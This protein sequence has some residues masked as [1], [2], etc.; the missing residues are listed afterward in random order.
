LP[1]PTAAEVLDAFLSCGRDACPDAARRIA[2]EIAA[3]GSLEQAA[4]GLAEDDAHA[5]L[6]DLLAYRA[7]LAER[8]DPALRL[9]RLY[10]EAA[11]LDARAEPCWAEAAEF[12]GRAAFR[13][14]QGESDLVSTF[15]RRA[16]AAEQVA[17]SLEDQA[18][19][20]RLEAAGLQASLA[21]RDNICA[22]LKTIAA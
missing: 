10:R 2:R 22:A 16:A 8:A 6:S 9:A 7:A 14:I 17:A 21:G 13:R 19:A 18:F 11:D 20:R 15:E 3:Y 1:T 4:A 12:A 5:L